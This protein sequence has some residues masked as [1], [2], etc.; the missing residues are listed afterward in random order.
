MKAQRVR[1]GIPLPIL[2]ITARRDG[3]RTPTP[4]HFTAG[5]ETGNH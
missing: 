2:N 5:K 1:R 4:D 3:R